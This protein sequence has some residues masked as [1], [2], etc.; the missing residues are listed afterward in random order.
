MIAC[1][2]DPGLDGGI[3]IL[4]EDGMIVV[5]PLPVLKAAKGGKRHFDLHG[6]RDILWTFRNEL[7][8]VVVEQVSSRSGEGVTSAFRFGEGYG[9]L[10]GMLTGMGMS[11]QMATPQAWKKAVLAG[12]QK[13]KQAAIG[14]IQRRFP[15]VDL[16]ATPR[17]RVPH[18]GMADVLCLALY[19][20]ILMGGES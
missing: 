3:A 17:S 19:A 7:H 11:Y 18:D 13:D 4:V 14:F 16:K 1:G 15:R 20:R 10:Q 6:I 12:T 2:I 9:M 8:L 5:R